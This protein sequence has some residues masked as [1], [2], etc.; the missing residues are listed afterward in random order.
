M[1]LGRRREEKWGSRTIDIDILFYG[2]SI[3]DEAGFTGAAPGTA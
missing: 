2:E 1:V 3:I